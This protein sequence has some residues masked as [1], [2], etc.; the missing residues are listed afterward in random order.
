M[1][2]TYT[3]GLETVPADLKGCVLTIGN[4]DGVHLGHQAIVGRAAELARQAGT[5]AA[6]MTF[7]PP[8]DLVVRPSDSPQRL[9]PHTLKRE[10]LQA[11]GADHVVTAVADMKLLSMTPEGFLHDIV[12]A[13]FSPS[14][15]VEGSDF[16]FGSKRSGD[17][18]TLRQAAGE[19]GFEMH[20]VD[21][22]TCRFT[23]GPL[24]ISSTMIRRLV[25]GGR[26]AD[27][28]TALGRPFTLVGTVIG[29]ERFGRLLQY[30]TANLAPDEQIT[31]A[32]GVY[33]GRA[34]VD[35]LHVPAAIS[36][37]CKPTTG[38][39]PRTI[40]ANLIGVDGEFY[41]CSMRLEFVKCLREQR[42]Y[43][44]CDAL[45]E[46]IARD[47]QQTKDVMGDRG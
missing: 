39:S 47:V 1:Q 33:A 40:E 36:I 15:I 21:P 30:P 28:A 45:R 17:V 23:N 44:N 37:G 22:I 46:Q 5:R 4:F 38:P 6:A 16:H 35:D 24:Q 13:T 41:G 43:D 25:A 31:P 12:A 9:T 26:V 10:L 2:E 3:K 7:D 8:P 14:H 42:T 18:E 32:D 20:V 19:M 29:G 11:A 27:A 34:T